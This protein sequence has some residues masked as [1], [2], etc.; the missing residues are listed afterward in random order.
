MRRILLLALA[1]IALSNSYAQTR[2]GLHYTKEELEIWRKRA[3]SGPYRIKGDVQTN[4]PGDWTRVL[5]EADAFVSNP[6]SERWVGYT[7]SG[8]FPSTSTYEPKVKGV[9]MQSAAFAWLITG[10]DKYLEPVKTELLWHAQQPLLDFT[11]SARWCYIGDSNPGF[12]IS[13]WV[14]K[15]MNSYD[16]IKEKLSPAERAILDKW[17]LG[18]GR[19]FA[20][21]VDTY[22]KKR[23]A[24]RLNGNYQLSTYSISCEKD[25]YK[26]SM[27][28]GSTPVGFLARGYNNRHGTNIRFVGTVGVFLDN[29]ELQACAKRWFFEWMRYGVYPSM[30]I[31]DL[32]RCLVNPST[33]PERGF[34]YV[35]SLAQ[36][37]SDLADVFARSGDNSLY[38][39]ATTEGYYG[40][41]SPG[42]PKTL[43]KVLENV[44]KYMNGT[45]KRYAS[46]TSTTNTN[47]LINGIDPYASPGEVAYDT[48]FCVAN[49]YY[50]NKSVTANYLRQAPGCRPYPSNPR[51]IGG[52]HTW[53][54]HAGIYPATLF[55]FGQLEGVTDPYS[56]GSMQPPAKPVIAVNGATEFCQGGSVVLSGPTGFSSYVWS[57]GANTRQIT[58]SESGNY[59]LKVVDQNGL[60]SPVSD[61]VA[62]KVTALPAQPL[63]SLS[64]NPA[65]CKGQSILLSTSATNGLTYQWKR[66]GLDIS[67]AINSELS[68]SEAGTY[69][70]VI[71]RNG[72]L[73]APSSPVTVTVT[74]LP[75]PTLTAAG[76]TDLE[77]GS[78]VVLNATQGDGYSYR[79]YRNG[80]LIAN[81]NADSYV[82]SQAGNYT[83]QI[84]LN[85]CQSPESDKITVT[86]TSVTQ[87][88][89]VPDGNVNFC[90]GGSVV[91]KSNTGTGLTYQWF[92]DGT[93]IPDAQQATYTATQSG[94]YTVIVSKNG[95]PMLPSDAVAVN[96]TPR[97]VPAIAA[98][99]PTTFCTSESVILEANQGANLSYQW[100]KNG[101]SIS[102]AT[103]STYKATESGT[104]AVEITQLHCQTST[105][106]TISVTVNQTTTPVIL[107]DGNT[108]FCEGDSVVL[109][110]TTGPNIVYQWK[111]DGQVIDNAIAAE[112][113]ATQ[114]GSYT[115]EVT[116]NNCNR[117]TSQPVVVK[118]NTTF[119]PTITASGSTVLCDRSDLLLSASIGSG[120][121]YQWQ[122]DGIYLPGKQDATL[123]VTEA[124][125]YSVVVSHNGCGS[126]LSNVIRITNST[127]TAPIAQISAQGSTN[128]CAGTTVTLAANT[129]DGLSYQWSRDGED[130]TDA[131]DP[132]YAAGQ[133]GEYS[134]EVTKEGCRVSV[135]NVITV[136]VAGM[137]S[138][139]IITANG[140]TTIL[141]GGS[142]T[143]STTPEAGLVYQWRKNGINIPQATNPSYTATQA[144][145]YTLA[146]TKN[147]CQQA[148]SNA[149]VVSVKTTN[150]NVPVIKVQGQTTFC[151][152]GSVKLSAPNGYSDYLWSTGATTQSITVTASGEYTV[153]VKQSKNATAQTSKAVKI[154]VIPAPTQPVITSEANRLVSTE[155]F[156]YQWLQDDQPISGAQSR[157]WVAVQ[158]GYYRVVVTNELGCAAIS[159]PVFYRPGTQPTTIKTQQEE[160]LIYPN[161]TTGAFS[162]SFSAEIV[163][164]E[165][166][167]DLTLSVINSHGRMVYKK[168]WAG[169]GDY[170]QKVDLSFLKYGV[171]TL[172]IQYGN[173]MFNRRL[174]K[175]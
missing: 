125:E 24:D 16:Y 26:Q 119:A 86:V 50:K 114:S 132:T 63:I 82:A 51:N 3:V 18:A 124:G 55:M 45:H 90:E 129:G 173:T 4:S 123:S 94:S 126:A 77:A 40:S 109:K 14:T 143:L 102:N 13:E 149:T 17:L 164:K 106:N 52:F 155:G 160:V 64:G 117:M 134:V 110:A 157:E 174:I 75:K 165:P 23:F 37:M 97:I 15:C 74:N 61:A 105:S 81:A 60:I 128:I 148:I 29:Q 133:S 130:I 95:L 170:Q 10:N 135:S 6:T 56:D 154:V 137:A 31:A 152:G 112:Y 166:S 8:C 21:N 12:N 30:D 98:N 68:T 91:I 89:A 54:G 151:E 116:Q 169:F 104:Y 107:A 88:T 167:A 142:V 103:A 120:Y 71:A 153:T 162:L 1:F 73:S 39:Y 59:T 28:Y 33:E 34:N 35:F 7:G 93:E 92:K 144:G 32:H 172:H 118:V 85:D 131:N 150:I 83:V 5:S 80:N 158:E 44:Q 145:S 67:Q 79:W 138:K 66:N 163:E 96:V 58:V 49:R 20:M 38:E 161:P 111:K 156:V 140:N 2:L 113:T 147:N 78:S 72:C 11:N 87:S 22:F 19:Y 168:T 136:S 122:K 101:Q 146:A 99:G 65:L 100:K 48:W 46:E 36:A 41:E 53:G 127:V 84:L 141:Q 139:P 70:V 115:V 171:Y 57:N 108:T 121:T 43:L 76:S 25:N 27:Y 42:N 159:E 47:V 62:V 69:T 9:R 175:E